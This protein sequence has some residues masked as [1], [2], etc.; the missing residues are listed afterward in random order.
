MLEKSTCGLYEP[1]F[2]DYLRDGSRQSAKVIVPLILDWIQPNSIVDVGCGDGTWLSVF[3]SHGIEEILGIDGDYV[4]SDMLQISA[5]HFMA[6]DL[7]QPVL[8]ARTFDLAMSL[9]VAEH[10]SEAHAQPFVKFL[11]QLSNVVLFSA[12]IPEQGGNHHVNEQ[13]PDYWISLF[14]AEGYTAVD[15]LRE[16]VWMNPN[17]QPWYAQNSFLFVKRD[18]LSKYPALPQKAAFSRSTVVHPRI[19]LHRCSLVALEPEPKTLNALELTEIVK[20]LGVSSHPSPKLQSGDPLTIQLDY[21]VIE[22]TESFAVTLNLSNEEG[23]V[24][25]STDTTVTPSPIQPL[26]PCAIQL[27]IERLDL[28][29]GTYYINPGIFSSDWEQTH[30]YHWHRY[31]IWVSAPTPKKGVIQPPT[32][33]QIPGGS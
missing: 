28:P 30:D 10:L 6:C 12:A 14:Q 26:E 18:R 20:I 16:Q 3:Q 21:K 25:F 8:P 32:R 22:P 9:E 31:P 5:E 2:F 1:D 7:S 29:Q 23:T 27:Q 4:N 33:W 17:V 24:L 19:Y 13:W 15:V 11:T